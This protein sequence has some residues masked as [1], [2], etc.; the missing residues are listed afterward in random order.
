[1]ASDRSCRA[2]KVV[3]WS[4]SVQNQS[5]QLKLAQV[6]LATHE[7]QALLATHEDQVLSVDTSHS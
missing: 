3:G 2:G 7:D 6:L 1:M 4:L 5:R